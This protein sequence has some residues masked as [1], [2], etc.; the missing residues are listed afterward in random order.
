MEHGFPSVLDGGLN[1]QTSQGQTNLIA[2][3]ANSL[4][5]ILPF[6]SMISSGDSSVSS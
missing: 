2:I 5:S 1:M 6:S 4:L 3:S